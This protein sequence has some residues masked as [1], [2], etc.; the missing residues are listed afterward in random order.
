MAFFEILFCPDTCERIL[1]E[2]DCVNQW[3][4]KERT[5]GTHKLIGPIKSVFCLLKEQ[6]H[7]FVSSAS[8]AY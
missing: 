1:S 3:R 2:N 8:D 5:K 6:L 7:S 4:G